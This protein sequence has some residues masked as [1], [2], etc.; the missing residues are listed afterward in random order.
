MDKPVIPSCL[1]IN[2][3]ATGHSL[4]DYVY[5]FHSMIYPDQV[6]LTLGTL[7]LVVASKSGDVSMVTFQLPIRTYSII[8]PFILMRYLVGPGRL[9]CG[10]GVW[11]ARCAVCETKA[12]DAI[13]V[14]AIGEKPSSTQRLR[15]AAAPSILL[16]E[17]CSQP[18]YWLPCVLLE[19]GSEESTV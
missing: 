18:Q 5:G 11:G 15:G 6:N 10:S 13:E 16:I 12:L 17:P 2:F 1:N 9:I 8:L 19:I 3:F 4:A 7:L 14:S